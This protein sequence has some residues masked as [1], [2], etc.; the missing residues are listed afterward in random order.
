MADHKYDLIKLNGARSGLGTYA[1]PQTVRAQATAKG[2][3][4]DDDSVHFIAALR[5]QYLEA[6]GRLLH[7]INT[8]DTV[9]LQLGVGD[10]LYVHEQ[11]IEKANEAVAAMLNARSLG[12]KSPWRV[13]PIE[14]VTE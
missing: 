13:V 2:R 6:R 14:E 8:M 11:I 7:A 12:G 3:N 5:E 1:R 4:W 10:P 9:A